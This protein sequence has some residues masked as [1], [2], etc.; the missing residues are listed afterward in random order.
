MDLTKT[1][2]QS[3]IDLIISTK[4]EENIHLEF[5]ASGSLT[6]SD[7]NKKELSKD[8]SSFANSDGGIIIYGI[9]EKNDKA[10]SVDGI[11][12]N[13]ITK[14][15][16]EQIINS[17]ISPKIH[18]IVIDVVRYNQDI[19]QTIYIVK[20]PRS[21]NAHMAKDNK[22]YKRYNFHSAPMEEF[23]VKDLYFRKNSPDLSILIP[24]ARG[25][26]QQGSGHGFVELIRV[27]YELNITNES[28]VPE[29]V[30]KYEIFVNSYVYLNN[31]S[32]PDKNLIQ[33]RRLS[34]SGIYYSFTPNIPI[35]KG[36]ISNI[37]RFTMEISERNINDNWDIE[38]KLYYSSGIKT[39]KY[40]LLDLFTID[41]KS[42]DTF[43]K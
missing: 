6:N 16:L 10:E 23:E 5:K 9:S 12:G 15:W 18:D 22:F 42:A 29:T 3:D 7:S 11:D 36:D 35:F 33:T 27:E 26:I 17:N 8:V 31:F 38:I 25:Y 40:N 41:G 1:Y 20:I 32:F 21:Y 2:T 37:C 43:F 34:G 4:Q 30:Y 14:E 24:Q 28:N 13:T 39:A 19:K